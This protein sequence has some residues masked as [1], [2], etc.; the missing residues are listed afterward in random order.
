MCCGEGRTLQT[1]IT[2]M[3]GIR[4]E[5]SQCLATLGLPPVTACVL[6]QSILLTL[7]VALQGNSLKPAPACMH[8]P[9]LSHSGSG[10]WI[11][12]KGTDLVQPV[13]CALPRP[14]QLRK[15]GAWQAH[16]PQ[17][18][19]CILLPPPLPRCSVSWVHSRSTI[20]SVPCVSSGELISGCDPPGRCQ[21]SQENLVSNWEPALSLV[22][23]AVSGAEIAP[24]WLW[25]SPACLSAS[26]RGWANP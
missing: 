3:Y 16:S 21:P 6:S 8:F 1:N 18:G 20:S 25:L 14:S 12:H 9:G 17:M 4:P 7:Q 10:S 11:F 15:L 19:Q 2:G 22:E 5:S 23:D 26:S 13:F 24:C